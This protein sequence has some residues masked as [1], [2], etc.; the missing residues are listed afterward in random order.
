MRT[1]FLLRLFVNQ[2]SRLI[3]SLKHT[4][5]YGMEHTYMVWK[6]KFLLIF[7]TINAF[8][9]CSCFFSCM[10]FANKRNSYIHEKRID[11]IE[12]FLI[13]NFS[14]LKLFKVKLILKNKQIFCFFLAY[15][16]VLI[17]VLLIFVIFNLNYLR[18]LYLNLN[19]EF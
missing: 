4:Y 16:V 18:E 9:I 8:L 10:H 5:I 7:H 11:H 19:Q 1:I 17:F 6:I 14:L 15:I 3:C 12:T 13:F 2:L